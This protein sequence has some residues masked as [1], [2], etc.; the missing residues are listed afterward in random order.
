LGNIDVLVQRP[1]AAGIRYRNAVGR[2]SD[3][4]KFIMNLQQQ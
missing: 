1:P 2:Q 4:F 3:P